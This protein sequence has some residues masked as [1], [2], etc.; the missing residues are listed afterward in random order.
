MEEFTTKTTELSGDYVI[1]PSVMEYILNFQNIDSKFN[2][3]SMKYDEETSRFYF[4]KDFDDPS[5]LQD[6]E[7]KLKQF[8]HSFAKREVKIPSAFFEKVKEEIKGNSY[9]FGT[10]LVDFSFNRSSVIFAGKKE[11]V[12]IKENLVCAMV[13]KLT[14]D[15]QEISIDFPITNKNKLKFLIFI[16]YFKKLRTEFPKVQIRGTDDDSEKLLILGTAEDVGIVE[17]KILYDLMKMSEIEIKLSDHQK[18]FLNITKCQTV[19]DEL[20]KDA[21]MLLLVQTAETVTGAND[22]QT[23]IVSMKKCG[24]SEVK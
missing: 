6:F 9:Q 24:D 3:K 4:T 20:K 23:K 19:N 11:D 7:K 18:D 15:A 21:R 12:V 16:D 8:L 22:F 14:E 1:E 17:R 5:L 13:N 10:D 2:L